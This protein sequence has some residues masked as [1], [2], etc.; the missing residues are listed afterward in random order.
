MIGEKNLPPGKGEATFRFYEELNDHLPEET[1]KKEMRFRFSKLTTIKEAIECLR[2]PPA[3][4]DLVLVNGRSVSLDYLL[5]GGDRVSVYPIFERFNISGITK[6]RERPLK[7]MLAR[8]RGD[9]RGI[10]PRE[11][12]TAST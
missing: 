11:K 2:V 5:E 6:V 9:Q 10:E 12:K 4:V 3:E 1:R 7:E 8:S